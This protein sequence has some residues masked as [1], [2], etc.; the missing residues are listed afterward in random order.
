MNRITVYG[1]NYRFLVVIKHHV[2][3][4]GT[5]THHMTIGENISTLGVY[6]ETSS[7]TYSGGFCVKIADMGELNGHDRLDHLCDRFLPRCGLWKVIFELWT[8][9]TFRGVV[10]YVFVIFAVCVFKIRICARS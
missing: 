1:T 10:I 6:N 5:W 3:A 2:S 8:H 4:K 7:F 9:F